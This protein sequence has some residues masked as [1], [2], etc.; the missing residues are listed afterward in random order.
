M[1]RKNLLLTLLMALMAPLATWAQIQST[2]LGPNNPSYETNFDTQTD[3]I[4]RNDVVNGWCID[5]AIY[6]SRDNSLYATATPAPNSS[7][8]EYYVVG[9]EASY[10]YMTHLFFMEA[11]VYQVDYYYRGGHDYLFNNNSYPR[12]ALVEGNPTITAGHDLNYSIGNSSVI[13]L[14][15]C[16]DNSNP[17][18]PLTRILP[19]RDYWERHTE[20]ITIPENGLYTLVFALEIPASTP[21]GYAW[22]MA[23]DDLS[24]QYI[25]PYNLTVSD[26][27]H[28]SANLSWESLDADSWEV[29]YRRTSPSTSEWIQKTNLTSRH[30]TLDNL[31]TLDETTNIEV[32]VRANF[33][34]GMNSTWVTT[35]FTAPRTPNTT[36]PYSTDFEVLNEDA[37]WLI[38]SATFCQTQYGNEYCT[39]TF[40][41]GALIEPHY[42]IGDRSLHVWNSLYADYNLR[43]FQ[44]DITEGGY[45]TYCYAKKSFNLTRGDYTI[46]FNWAGQGDEAHGYNSSGDF[47]GVF[48]APVGADLNVI[49]D[50]MSRHYSNEGVIS[51][52]NLLN[53]DYFVYNRSFSTSFS[54]DT[55]TAGDYWLVFAWFNDLVGEDPSTPRYAFAVDNLTLDRTTTFPVPTDL[56]VS[57]TTNSATF[58]WT[59]QE[60]ATSYTIQY[61]ESSASSWTTV[62]PDTNPYT[63]TGLTNNTNYVAQMRINYDNNTNHSDWAA[64]DPFKT[65]LQDAYP[66]NASNTSYYED[67]ESGNGDWVFLNA[68]TNKWRRFSYNNQFNGNQGYGLRVTSSADNALTPSWNY[69]TRS[70]YTL[71]GHTNY[72]GTPATSYALKTFALTEGHYE[73][74]Y[75]YAVKGVANEDYMRVVL[76]PAETEIVAG[77][78]PDGFDYQSTP[79]G[80]FS[81]DQGHQL[82]GYQAN[83][84]HW[85][86]QITITLDVYPGSTIDPG[87]YMIVVLWHNPG[88]TGRDG[89]NPPGAIDNVSI[90]WSPV[91][92][93]PVFAGYEATDTEA[94]LNLIAPGMGISPTS[95]E[96]Q[97]EPAGGNNNFVDAPIANFNVTESPQ[98]V[99]LTGLTPNTSYY[100]R[101]RSAYTANGTTIYSDWSGSQTISTLYPRPTDLAVVYQTTNSVELSWTPVE[102]EHSS[103]Q[104]VEYSWQLTTDMNN[105]GEENDGVVSASWGRNLAVGTY[106]FRVRAKLY[107]IN[108]HAYLAAGVW[109]EPL[110][111]TIAPWTDPLTVFP[112]S[113]DFEA[114][115]NIPNGM[116][117]DG[118]YE[119]FDIESN[120]YSGVPAHEGSESE[121]ILSFNS[122]INQQAYLVLPPLDPSTPD[123][124]VSFWWYHHSG[125]VNFPNTNIN[126]GVE[127][128]TST[129][130]QY[131]TTVSYGVI[132][133]Y[134]ANYSGWKKY[135]FVFPATANPTYL[136]LHFYGT[137]GSYLYCYLDDLT[138]NNFQSYQPYISYV[139]CN[140]DTA[141]ITLYDYGYTTGWPSSAF[142]VQYRE[143]RNPG[144]PEEEWA[145]SLFDE[146]EPA[147]EHSLLVGG[148]QPTTLYEFRAC[149]RASYGGFDFPWSDYSTPYRQWTDCG[150]YT[151]TPTR[152]YTIDFEDEFY[153]NC[154]SGDI[155]ETAWHVTTDDAHSGTKSFYVEN[156]VTGSSNLKELRTPP[157]DLTQLYA[158]TDNVVLRFWVNYTSSSNSP[159]LRMTSSVNVYNSSSTLYQLCQIPLNTDGWTQIE[160]SL[161]KQMG[162]VITI[163]FK[164]AQRSHVM[165]YI[166]DI[167]IVANPYPGVKIFDAGGYNYASTWTSSNVWYPNGVPTA[168]DDVMILEGSPSIPHASYNSQVKSIVIGH[169]GDLYS[170]TVA[171]SLTVIEDV[172]THSRR[173]NLRGEPNNAL[174]IGATTTFTAQSVT[175][176]SE[177]PMQVTGVANITTLNP[178][179]ANS[180]IVNDGGVL[181]ATTITTANAG[182]N[183]RVVIKDGGQVKTENTFYATIEKDITG[184]GADNVNNSTGWNLVAP[185]TLVM[186]V[187]TFVPQIDSQYQFDQMDLYWFD[188]HQELE[189]IN[190]KCPDSL[191]C[192]SPWGTI[193]QGQFSAEV[194][195]PLHGYLYARQDDGTVQFAAGSVDNNPFPATNVNTSVD[196][197]FYSNNDAPLNGWN[198]IGNP[199]TCNAY[200]KQGGNYIPFYKMNDTGDAIVGV[201]AGTPIKPCEGVFVCCTESTNTVTFTTT[202]PVGLGEIPEDPMIQL[203]THVLYEDQDASMLSMMTQTIELASGVNWVSFNVETDLDALKAALVAAMP[204]S[205]VTI[206]AKDDGQTFYNG[207]RWR[208]ALASLDMAQMYRITVP[209]ACE[210]VLEGMPVDPASHPITIKSG[211][212]W[213]G[214][215]FMEGMTITDA[216]AGFAVSGDEVRAKD[217]GIAKYVGTRW[218]G[219]LTDLVPGQGY[220]YNSAAT[221]D[222]TFVFPTSAKKVKP[223]S[224][225]GK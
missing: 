80:W 217:D 216:F 148:L 67:F 33:G 152:S 130:G 147:F 222:R 132:S 39:E 54:I 165:W 11:G 4:P 51:I 27:D 224:S 180:V 68:S 17:S 30:C 79:D 188:G 3:W 121:K 210:I 58:S 178:G 41:I 194:G 92:Y 112:L 127:V 98:A 198:L 73:F 153:Y 38:S 225:M 103:N 15:L 77:T 141:T 45:N 42:T 59:G 95:Y 126:D 182:A 218:R 212:N 1:K 34:N 135:D 85:K 52:A 43:Y 46:A 110:E 173:Y 64:F 119:R 114:S 53:K 181:N 76:V 122:G 35:Q 183:D 160:L 166:D 8:P 96:V 22:I 97:Y 49:L 63:L 223:F 172:E 149:A 20:T 93:E 128:E 154:W 7:H 157:I 170:P 48:L 186:A 109:S 139:G 104:Q 94:T 72:L 144:E 105:W 100:F 158:S 56:A 201:A 86:D 37:D 26:V 167:E 133:R 150:T 70:S 203:P 78:L 215:P 206:A 24:I 102:I 221:G 10:S 88:T 177:C 118:H 69:T 23:F 66:L 169:G 106:Y 120:L 60:S 151:I 174:S 161:S 208:G 6:H 29:Q 90:A 207:T 131:W 75:R 195:Q 28:L 2:D 32:Q 113:Y 61:K 108:A 12:V 204:V 99:T 190:P 184:Y 50:R 168:S 107:D 187:P 185:T 142:Q 116:T 87:N 136:R 13:Y 25:Q 134:N 179:A 175:I 81:L 115:S 189:W 199:Y 143:Y 84:Y 176:A 220:I 219:A 146:E 62:T 200:L 16:V 124:L 155:S 14:D 192:G 5:D 164:T 19:Y 18:I 159:S 65:L 117:L 31:P 44:R 193:P 47:L 125:H 137:T 21:S 162:D 123:A 89:Q 40:V 74:T 163:G 129:D 205:G 196:L 101:I 138:V 191:G 55:E 211:L 145:Y 9:T 197:E 202:E 213:I 36:Y 156:N 140:A 83:Y 214:Y 171:S 82:T 111:F 91:I 71:N 209:A 57:T